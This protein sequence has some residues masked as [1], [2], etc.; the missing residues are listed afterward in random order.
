LN[1][2]VYAEILDSKNGIEGIQPQNNIPY[3][4]E[5]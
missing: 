2:E 4:Q 5:F 3:Q 1:G